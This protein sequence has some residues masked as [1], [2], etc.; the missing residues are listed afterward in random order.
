MPSIRMSI[1]IECNIGFY[2]SKI[3]L[4]MYNQILIIDSFN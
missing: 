3:K 4:D 2:D 1:D